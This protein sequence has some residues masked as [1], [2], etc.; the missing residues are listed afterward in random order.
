MSTVIEQLTVIG[1]RWRNGVLE[2]RVS[3]YRKTYG[4]DQALVGTEVFSEW[5]P[6]P[7]VTDVDIASADAAQQA[8]ESAVS[9]GLMAARKVLPPKG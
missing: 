3:G 1:N 6:V 8:V 5:R 2:M 9:A 4:D 7:T